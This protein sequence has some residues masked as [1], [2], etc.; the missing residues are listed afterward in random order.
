MRNKF[1]G[2]CVICNEEEVYSKE[3]TPN[4]CLNCHHQNEMENR[5]MTREM[6]YDFY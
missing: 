1:N 5:G 2:I 4:L 3:L 6:E